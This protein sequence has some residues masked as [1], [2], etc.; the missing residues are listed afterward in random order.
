M[1]EHL[2]HLVQAAPT[3]T[4]GRNLAREYLRAVAWKPAADDVRP[5]L[6]S[7]TDADLLTAENLMRLLC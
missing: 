5:F 6:D 3:P 7:S 1:K 4:H 2:I